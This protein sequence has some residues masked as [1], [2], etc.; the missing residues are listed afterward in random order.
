M[1]KVELAK[2]LT[3]EAQK[4]L[5]VVEKGGANKGPEVEMFQKA[6]DGKAAG[7]PWCAAFMMYCI[8]QVEKATGVKSRLFKSEHVLTLWNKSPADLRAAK[9]Q[10]G[11]LVIWQNYRDGRPTISGHVG[12]VVEHPKPNVIFTIEGNTGPEAGVNREG[13]GVYKKVRPFP[14]VSKNM[15]IKGFLKVW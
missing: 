3:L 2:L 12:I 10:V 8:E 7:E 9:P 1:D 11:S 5:G 14:S 13:D 6:L 15:Q 4:W